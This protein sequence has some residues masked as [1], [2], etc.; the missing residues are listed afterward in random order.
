MLGCAG[1]AEG[2]GGILFLFSVDP[3]RLEFEV[4]NDAGERKNLLRLLQQFSF[5]HIWVDHDELVVEL[6]SDA[7]SMAFIRIKSKKPAHES[8]I[9]RSAH[10]GFDADVLRL[11]VLHERAVVLLHEADACSRK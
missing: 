11:K 10:G 2:F 5:C 3:S 9:L 1:E 4:G 7:L 6:S 8:F